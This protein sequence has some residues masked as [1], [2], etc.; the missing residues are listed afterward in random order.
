MPADWQ[1]VT[2]LSPCS[3]PFAGHNSHHP[4]PVPIVGAQDSEMLVRKD[5]SMATSSGH[6]PN[7]PFSLPSS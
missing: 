6:W 1:L 5:K 4:C 3:V 2:Q 7:L